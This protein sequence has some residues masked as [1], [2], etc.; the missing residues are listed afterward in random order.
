MNKEL[1]CLIREAYEH[2]GTNVAALWEIEEELHR[3]DDG[4][5]EKMT[6]GVDYRRFAEILDKYLEPGVSYLYEDDLELNYSF[7]RFPPELAEEYHCRLLSIGPVTFRPWS[8]K[9]FE[10]LM[11]ELGVNRDHYMDYLEYFNHVPVIPT[12]DIWNHMMGFFLTKLCGRAPEFRYF[13]FQQDIDKEYLESLDYSNPNDPNIASGII[14]ERYRLEALFMEGVAE[15][16]AEKAY[17]H[18]RTF[19]QY[20]FLP[21][22]PDPVR[23]KKNFTIILNTL[24]RK[25]AQAGNV[26]PVYIDSL[27]RQLAI[28]IEQCLT[29]Q[30]LERLSAAM[31]R[32]Y[33][34]L[35]RNYSRRSYSA[36]V[37]TCMDHIDFH[38]SGEISLSSLAG[39]CSVSAN[40]LSGLFKRETGMTITDYVNQTRV[41]RALV[42]L[43]TTNYSMG[44]I[45]TQCGFSDA[46]YFSRIFK[47]YQGISPREYRDRIGR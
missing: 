1:F 2:Y 42:L 28:Q 7:F 38:Y 13:S 16:N 8:G 10:Q 5:R 18:Y 23:N 44:E 27:S 26:H 34:M 31:I 30:D 24:L 21:R 20:R 12:I 19:T 15:G 35:V 4:F 41:R 22:V 32:K 29:V 14:E 36:L 25:G 39:L 3:I 47:K 11:E 46:N 6:T 40:Y 9:R 17:E 37:Q 43:N 33:S 45:A